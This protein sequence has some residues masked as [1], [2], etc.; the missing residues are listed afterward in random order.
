MLRVDYFIHS[1]GNLY[2][3]RSSNIH[4]QILRYC[5]LEKGKKKYLFSYDRNVN[6]S[7]TIFGSRIRIVHDICGNA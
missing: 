6:F 4:P 1:G 7:I 3:M 5:R 2:F